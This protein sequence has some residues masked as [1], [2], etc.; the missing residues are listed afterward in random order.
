MPSARASSSPWPDASSSP[1]RMS[2]TSSAAGHVPLYQFGSVDEL[3]LPQGCVL[4]GVEITD[5]AIELPSFRH[6][7]RA[8][9]VFGA[10][11]FSLS[12][13]DARA[14]RPRR[15]D[16]DQLLHQC[17]HGG[18][19]H[20]LRPAADPRAVPRAARF[21][22][23][24]RRTRATASAGLELGR[25]ADPQS[26]RKRLERSNSRPNHALSDSRGRANAKRCVCVVCGLDWSSASVAAC[27]V[28]R[29]RSRAKSRTSSAR[30]RT[31]TSIRRGRARTAP[32]TR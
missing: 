6:P 8:A 3:R 17:R 13:A 14:L 16:S 15:E 26:A 23:A 25:A 1:T 30:S 11:R 27:V 32:A 18:R 20:A 29:R 12:P 2:D 31:G 9:Y 24:V 19:D 28:R 4:V 21:A 7:L 22:P 5:D 10:E